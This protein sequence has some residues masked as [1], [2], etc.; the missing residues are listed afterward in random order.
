MQ[1]TRIQSLGQ[2]DLLKNGYP[3]QYSCLE[4]SMDRRA[5]LATVHG[6]AKS[7]TWL[8]DLHFHFSPNKNNINKIKIIDLTSS[9]LDNN[10]FAETAS[11][12]GSIPWD[13]LQSAFPF[14]NHWRRHTL[15]ALEPD[16]DNELSPNNW[17]SNNRPQILLPLHLKCK[18]MSCFKL[19][20][21]LCLSSGPEELGSRHYT[22]FSPQSQHA[23]ANLMPNITSC[24]V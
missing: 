7:Q 19:Y 2:E 22:G 17:L 18:E 16:L 13:G 23:T 24:D 20:Q 9:L 3:F 6:V 12:I 15:L 8:S 21:P 11:R 5:W 4:K 10:C 14:Q 1:E